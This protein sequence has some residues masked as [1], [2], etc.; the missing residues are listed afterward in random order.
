MIR[1]KLL[2]VVLRSRI[3]T[4]VVIN[5]YRPIARLKQ[6][7]GASKLVKQNY[8]LPSLKKTPDRLGSLKSSENIKKAVDDLVSKTTTLHLH[9]TFRYISFQILYLKGGRKQ[10]TT[11][12]SFSF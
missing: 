9:H 11:K 8:P 3:V 12:F 1:S 4:D 7:V 6:L 5:K 10:T 2:N